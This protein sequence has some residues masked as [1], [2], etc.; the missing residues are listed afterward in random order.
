MGIGNV[1][2]GLFTKAMMCLLFTWLYRFRVVT[3]PNVWWVWVV[4]FFA[5]RSF[6]GITGIH[7]I[8]S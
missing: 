6:S 7:L 8:E 3:L 5:G 1:I 4:A 2:V